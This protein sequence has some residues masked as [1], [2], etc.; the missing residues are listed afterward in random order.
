[1]HNRKKLDR[2]PTEKELQS[3]SQ[4]ALSYKSLVDIIFERRKLSD[5]SVETL[6]LTGKMLKLNPDFYTLWNFRREILHHLHSDIDFSV[7]SPS[8][9]DLA[10]VR[11]AELALAAEGISRNPKSCKYL[12]SSVLVVMTLVDGAWYHRL[13]VIDRFNTNIEEELL[14]CTEFLK[15]D[16]RNFHCWNYRRL[17]HQ[18]SN[19]TY[20]SELDYALEKIHENFSN[21]SAFHHRSVFLNRLIS[22]QGLLS[23]SDSSLRLL[24]LSPLLENELDIVVN[25]VY[26][27]PDDQSAWW[28]HQYLCRFC[29]DLLCDMRDRS[30][31]M[32]LVEWFSTLLLKQIE[33][34]E[35]LLALENS[36]CRLAM[37][38]VV[39][40]IDLLHQ[41]GLSNL[42]C[43]EKRYIEL[44]TVRESYLSALCQL[45]PSHICRYRYLLENQK[46]R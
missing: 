28:Y 8:K 41:K 27:E 29:S 46:A 44:N 45:D 33:V 34:V 6:D 23:S 9:L 38:S 32:I 11:D 39:F 37:N 22:D 15:A 43:I 40:M 2:L 5:F 26:T 17:V 13:W 16:Q 12:R 31:W 4:K 42:A 3:Q 25:A 7:T 19:G 30:A 21:Y 24:H 35:Q 36:K 14:L 20:H 1:M 10:S 18:K